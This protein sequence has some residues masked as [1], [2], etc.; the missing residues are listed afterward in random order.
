MDTPYDSGILN[1]F[2]ILVI[3]VIGYGTKF[4]FEIQF[5]QSI[6]TISLYILLYLG[7]IVIL[8]FITSIPMRKHMKSDWYALL[9]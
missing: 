6:S 7:I 2:V 9:E 1:L 3:L 4:I 5:I 8:G